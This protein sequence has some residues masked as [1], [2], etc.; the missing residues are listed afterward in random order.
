MIRSHLA[1]HQPSGR[2]SDDRVEALCRQQWREFGTV[3][4]NID[5]PRLAWPEREIARQV[6]ERLYGRRGA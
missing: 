6:G 2:T 5:D 3:V 4:I 1:R